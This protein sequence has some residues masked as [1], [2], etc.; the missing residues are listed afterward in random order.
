M[1]Q[2]SSENALKPFPQTLSSRSGNFIVRQPAG[3]LLL[4]SVTTNLFGHGREERGS[5][6]GTGN[7]EGKHRKMVVVV[8]VVVVVVVG[9]RERKGLL[10]PFA[11][12]IDRALF[13][14]SFH[15][16]SF[17]LPLPSS[18]R[19]RKLSPRIGLFTTPSFRK[20]PPPP[21]FRGN[22]YVIQYGLNRDH[23]ILRA[24]VRASPY[25]QA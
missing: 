8:A 23:R 9:Y 3:R 25:F 16:Q 10:L 15:P 20:F 17:S 12:G 4:P 19:A 21:S 5:S 1:H 13:Q 6:V 22:I 11:Q 24:P 7:G 2:I 18:F 14:I